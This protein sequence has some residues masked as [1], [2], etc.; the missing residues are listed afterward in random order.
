LP[1]VSLMPHV[2]RILLAIVSNETLST[3]VQKRDRGALQVTN[4]QVKM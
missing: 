4:E 3:G 2:F 1:M